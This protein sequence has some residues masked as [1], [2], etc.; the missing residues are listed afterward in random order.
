MTRQ[1]MK[2]TLRRGLNVAN[3][4][5][6]KAHGSKNLS[7]P[8]LGVVLPHLPGEILRAV[9]VNFSRFFPRPQSILVDFPLFSVSFSQF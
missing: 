9:L 2:D 3:Y 8:L 6:G 7:K 4:G 5:V 1:N